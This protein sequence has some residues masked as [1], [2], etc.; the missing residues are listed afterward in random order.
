MDELKRLLAEDPH[1][2]GRGYTSNYLGDAFASQAAAAA[3]LTPQ[4]TIHWRTGTGGH[5]RQAV[6]TAAPCRVSLEAWSGYC[7]AFGR[8]AS[9]ARAAAPGA[10]GGGGRSEGCLSA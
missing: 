6:A 8:N 7:D 9:S 10:A 4:L 5:A 1:S 2:A 3:P